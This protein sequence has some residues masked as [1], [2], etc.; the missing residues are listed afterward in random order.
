MKNTDQDTVGIE[1]KTITFMGFEHR[2]GHLRQV[3]KTVGVAVRSDRTKT[4]TTRTVN[5]KVVSSRR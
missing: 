5:V 2:D 1:T 4:A 3:P